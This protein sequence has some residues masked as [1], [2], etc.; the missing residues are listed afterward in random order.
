MFACLVCA[1]DRCGM[2]GND[3]ECGRRR[4]SG[5]EDWG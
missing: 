3:E 5:A 4:R 2:V 1:G